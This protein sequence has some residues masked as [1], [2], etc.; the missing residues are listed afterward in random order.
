[1]PRQEGTI[2]EISQ[3]AG[4]RL[5]FTIVSARIRL[6]FHH[7]GVLLKFLFVLTPDYN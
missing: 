3:V 4:K 7:N 5:I 1:M 2:Y 6:G